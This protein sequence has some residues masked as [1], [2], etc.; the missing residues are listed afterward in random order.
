MRLDPVSLPDL[1]ARAR[2]YM[3]HNVWDFVAGACQDG[4]TLRRN[5]EMLEAICLRPRF[6]RDV[7]KRD[8]STTV[9]GHKISFPVMLAPAGGHTFVHPD[10]E[11]ASAKAAGAAGTIMGLSTSSTYSIEEVAAVA[12]APLFFQLYHCGEGL[13]KMLVRRAEEAGYKAIMLTVDT[14]LPSSKEVD[15]R[16]Q[17]ERPTGGHMGNFRGHDANKYLP[18]GTEISDF[19]ERPPTIPFTFDQIPWLKSLTSLPLVI[20]G[21]RT[22]EDAAQCVAH[23]ADAILCSNHGGRQVDGTL[24]SIETLPE[25]VD[26]VDGKAE[27]YFDSGIRRGSDIFKAL[28]LGARAVFIGR[29]IF[30]GLAVDGEKGVRR[31]LEILRKELDVCMG[32]CGYTSLDQLDPGALILPPEM[33]DDVPGYIQELRALA[34]LRDDGILTQPEFDARKKQLLNSNGR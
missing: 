27:V 31:A 32:Y 2:D 34:S 6:L 10:G 25:I 19:W 18:P 3:P 8:I 29:P 13:S 1:E 21:I 17:W 22:G 11:L 33:S 7:S 9:L 24:S 5:R 30:W 28:A 12:T 16:N 20:K 26:A 14:P 15:I 4:V 23:G